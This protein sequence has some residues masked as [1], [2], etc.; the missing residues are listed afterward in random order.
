M[1]IRVGVV[2]CGLIGRRRAALAAASPRCTLVAVAD[3]DEGRAQELAEEHGC[4]FTSDWRQLVARPDLDAVV[5]ST[6][7]KFLAPIAIGALRAGRHVLCEKPM[8]RNAMEAADMLAAARSSKRL[9]KIG[10]TLRFQPGLRQAHHLCQQGDLGPLFFV[11]AVY[12][13]G[14]RPGYDKEWRGNA[15]LA[16]GGELLDQGVHLLDLARWFLGD[17]HDVAAFA[18]RWFWDIPPLEDNAFALLRTA[19]GQVASLHTSWT[20]W[21]NRFLFEVYGRDGYVK[22]E[23]LGGS[24]GPQTLVLGRRQPQSGPPA[25]EQQ[26]FDGP[27][28]SWD[29]DW[30]DFLDAA[31]LGRSPEVNGEEGLSAMR[32]V[33]RVYDAAA[34]PGAQPLGIEVSRP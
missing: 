28:P 34:A 13:H 6:P 11:R 2:G 27:D 24:Y 20:Q 22:V 33:Q 25:E 14:G 18:P 21:R 17:F 23:G 10:F 1:S 5:V 31:E 9:L 16:G 12:G 30:Q 3:V 4:A 19:G 7:N 8:G 15:D 29:L 26:V 32:L